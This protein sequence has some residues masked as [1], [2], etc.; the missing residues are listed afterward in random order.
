MK[1][2]EY[3][4][5][6]QWVG[7]MQCPTCSKITGAW[8][9]SGMS[10]CFPHF[11]CDRCSNV[12]HRLKDQELVYDGGSQELLD[13]ISADLPTCPCGGQFRPGENP[14]C[15]HCGAA[16]PHLAGPVVRLGDHQMIVVDGACVLSDENEPY[17][18]RITDE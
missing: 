10:M 16:F 18:V 8:R 14:K 12:I 5:S 17:R 9:S 6:L 15:R 3:P 4:K 7:T 2:V 13:Q 11:Y 1:I